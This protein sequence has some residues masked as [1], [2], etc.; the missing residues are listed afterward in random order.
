MPDGESKSKGFYTE[1]IKEDEIDEVVALIR[2]NLAS[3]QEAG[4]VLAATYRRLNQFYMVYHAKGSAYVTAKNSE[5]K[6]VGGAGI[7]A[8]AG[9]SP[10]EKIGEIR[11]LVVGATY[12]GQG[13]G[14]IILQS[15]IDRAIDIG[16]E[17]IYL[18]TTPQMKR[19][20]KLFTGFGFRPVSLGENQ[21]QEE[22]DIPF[23]FML[24]RTKN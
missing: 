24:D 7:G 5:G 3:F 10:S 19:A 8:F 18:E 9:L 6:I 4:S 23:Y 21:S 2:E 15:C 1:I 16:Y 14:R 11:E 13:A 20:Q 22:D 17:R 12:R